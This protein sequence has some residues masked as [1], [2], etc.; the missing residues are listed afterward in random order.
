MNLL[1]GIALFSPI[2]FHIPNF[3]IIIKNNHWQE[4]EKVIKIKIIL[5]ILT[6]PLIYGCSTNES[7]GFTEG[8][9][10]EVSGTEVVEP[11]SKSEAIQTAETGIDVLFEVQQMTSFLDKSEEFYTLLDDTHMIMASTSSE[12]V[13]S[14]ELLDRVDTYD[15]HIRSL[16]NLLSELREIEILSDYEEPFNEFI[17]YLDDNI[18]SN[19]TVR[20]SVKYKSEQLYNT[21]VAQRGVL[22]SKKDD[23]EEKVAEALGLFVEEYDE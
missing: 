15:E 7:E 16:E 1:I 12:D 17:E 10:K 11:N 6:I 3:L 14:G 13:L 5:L 21:G 2:K 19:I 9:T 23:I 8:E 4:E 22:A 18:D 20:D